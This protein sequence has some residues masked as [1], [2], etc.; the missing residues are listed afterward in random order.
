MKNLVKDIEKILF[1]HDEIVAVSKRIA[2]EIEEDYRDK[3]QCPVLLC[4]LKG[5]LPFMAELIKH[6]DI[7]V[8]TDFIDVSSYHG[9]TEST[10]KIIIKK[11]IDMDIKNRDV[12]I[13][14]DI[15]DTG[16]T[17]KALIEYLESR[18]VKS[19]ACASLVDKPEARV[20]EVQAEYIGLESPKLFVVGFGLDYEEKYRN[21]PY[22]GVLKEE[23]YTK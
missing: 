20:V 5:A 22:I 21:L 17:L 6:I 23:I 4:T 11:D 13:V 12:I 9:G 8:V 1:N 10:G 18:G 14:E 3:E 7:H 15:V 19:I 2:K 16:R